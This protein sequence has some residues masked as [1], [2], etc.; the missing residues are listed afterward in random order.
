MAT[1]LVKMG[2]PG[3]Q[4]TGVLDHK[5]ER[6]NGPIDLLSSRSIAQQIKDA[7]SPRLDPKATTA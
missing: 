5:E 2:E 3:G 6:S 4:S 1:A 7:E